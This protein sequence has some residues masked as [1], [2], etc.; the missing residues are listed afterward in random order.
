MK[1]TLRYLLL[2]VLL[3][4]PAVGAAQP[5]PPDAVLER[6]RLALQSGDADAVLDEAADRLEIDLLGRRKLY[7]RAQA[8]Y[9]LREFFRRYPPTAFAF[10]HDSQAEGNWFAAGL[11]HVRR[12]AGPLHVYVR[13]RAHDDGWVLRELSLGA[14]GGP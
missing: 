8:A 6:L 10:D 9:V 14:P 13:L 4:L 7:S 2:A 11:L 3:S 1:K 12:G 5:Q